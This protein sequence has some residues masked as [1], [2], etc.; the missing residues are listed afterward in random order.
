MEEKIIKFINLDSTYNEIVNLSEKFDRI[1][2]DLGDLEI[3]PQFLNYMLKLYRYSIKN[4]FELIFFIQNEKNKNILN[5]FKKYFKIFKNYDEFINMR[6]Y[7]NFEVKMYMNNEYMRNLLK[8]ILLN[9]GF[10]IK[11]RREA[12]FLNKEHD[13]KST[14]IYIIDYDSYKQEKINEIIK[15]K[16]KNPQTTVILLV[17]AKSTE[18]A[19]KTV[20]IGVD[21]IVEKPINKEELLKI[22]KKL[23]IQTNLQLENNSLNNKI[24][25]LYE[26]LDKELKLAKDI[27]QSM[28]PP[29]NVEFKGYKI[30]YIFNPSQ[31]IGGDFLDIIKLDED[32]IAVLFADISGHGI[33]AAL[34]SSMLNII[35]KSEI[36]KYYKTNEFLEALNEK[37]IDVF[38]KG[39]FVS[40][41]YLIIDTKLNKISYC[42]S[43]QEPALYYINSKVEELE[44]SGQ[45]LGVFS[46]KMFKDMIVF[47]E[48]QI[49]FFKE[50]KILLYTDGIT[51]AQ[52]KDGNFYGIDKLKQ[53]II[54]TNANIYEIEKSTKDYK[55]VDDLTLL[56]I[57]RV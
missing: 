36:S 11:E 30:S 37:I 27:Q 46:K 29:K 16:N 56:V 6:V 51:E 3:N 1:I 20:D 13:S 40:V 49:D 18:A 9:N 22:I 34:L 39:K 38:P 55:V 12:N 32:R 50:S 2:L 15:I 5:D 48:K 44:T 47:E 52:D 4:S 25:K 53:E 24:K 17:S 23:A 33:P 45:I 31:D 10:R 21:S 54:L 28:L 8:D 42:R 26:N 7:I 19:I 41:F 57:E 35:I 43:S 14:D